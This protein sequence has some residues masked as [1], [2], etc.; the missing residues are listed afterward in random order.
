M[1]SLNSSVFKSIEGTDQM[2]SDQNMG[3]VY[4]A[5]GSEQSLESIMCITKVSWADPYDTVKPVFFAK[6]VTLWK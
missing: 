6:C 5:S 2:A 4:L 3:C 1:L